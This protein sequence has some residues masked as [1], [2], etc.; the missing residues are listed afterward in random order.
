MLTL[1]YVETIIHTGIPTDPRR[2][3]SRLLL[4]RVLNIAKRTPFGTRGQLSVMYTSGII[5]LPERKPCIPS[6]E[7]ATEGFPLTKRPPS[8]MSL[9][10]E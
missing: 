7:K 10:Y 1:S 3:R 6:S 9:L 4:P 2:F 5:S 8:P